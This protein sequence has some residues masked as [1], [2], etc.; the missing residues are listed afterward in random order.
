MQ[1]DLKVMKERVLADPGW[2]KEYHL[3][4][5]KREPFLERFPADSIIGLSL[6][7]WREFCHG[8]TGMLAKVGNMYHTAYGVYY[9]QTKGAWTLGDGYTHEPDIETAFHK[10]KQDVTNL[11]AWSAAGEWEKINKDTIPLNRGF[12]NDILSVYRLESF[13][14]IHSKAKLKTC[15]RCAGLAYDEKQDTLQNILRLVEIGKPLFGDDML[16]FMLCLCEY[17]NEQAM[18]EKVDSD[19]DG[20]VGE[21]RDAIVKVRV[22]QSV[23]RDRLI[24][25][26]G[27]KFC[28]C[29]VHDRQLLV[30]S[31]IKPWAV[32]TKDEKVN[33]DNGLLLCPNHDKL[34]D[35][36]W[37]SFDDQGKLMVSPQLDALHRQIFGLDENLK[38]TMTPSMASFMAYHRTHVF[39]A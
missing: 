9:N 35:G 16:L 22:N 1:I 18:I 29:S 10:I 8:V 38:I 14:P 27:E 3:R 21:V 25:A 2:M 24:A 31:H 33:P 23:F 28:L 11:L 37:I 39:R 36:G 34:F 19:L 32:A 5:S 30:A 26:H 4:M 6:D 12:R 20:V 15:Y 7:E 17:E 13:V